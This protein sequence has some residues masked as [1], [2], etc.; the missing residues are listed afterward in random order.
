MAERWV[1]YA[2]IGVGGLALGVV[3]YHLFYKR[4]EEKKTTLS[5]ILD[6]LQGSNAK[7]PGM[8]GIRGI[9]IDRMKVRDP[10]YL[11]GRMGDPAEPPGWPFDAQSE[12]Q[13]SKQAE[14]ILQYL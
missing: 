1:N 14:L 5:I 3:A 8:K 12:L 10:N 4:K 7:L 9:D 6:A 2:L 11:V 13:Q